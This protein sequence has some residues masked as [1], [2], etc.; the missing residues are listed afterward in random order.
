MVDS[1]TYFIFWGIILLT[2]QLLTDCDS[3]I[4]ADDIFELTVTNETQR[5]GKIVAGHIVKI[6]FS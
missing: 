1:C 3:T 6:S 5:H 2:D 4:Y